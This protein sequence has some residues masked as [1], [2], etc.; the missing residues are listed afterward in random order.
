MTKPLMFLAFA[1]L[2]GI[3]VAAI[4]IAIWLGIES[5]CK[6]KRKDYPPRKRK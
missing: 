4:V 3:C 1:A 6:N 5:Y 2:L